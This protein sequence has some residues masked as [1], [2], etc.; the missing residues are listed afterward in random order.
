[1]K[2]KKACLTTLAFL[3]LISLVSCKKKKGSA[4]TTTKENTVVT[5]ESQNNNDQVDKKYQIYLLAQTSGFTGTYEE[6]LESIKGDSV[7]ITVS[8]GKLK[9]KYRNESDYKELLDLSTL[10]G[11]DGSLSI[12]TIGDNGNWF[13]DGEDTLVKARATDG[14]GIVSITK[15]GTVGLVDT[16]T[17]TFT[18]GSETE[19]NIT[20]GQ[21][22]TTTTITSIEKTDT[23]GLVDTY[24]ITFSDNSYY[25]FYVTNGKDGE[26]S[27]VQEGT[28]YRIKDIDGKMYRET[29]KCHGVDRDDIFEEEYEGYM[30]ALGEEYI[31]GWVPRYQDVYTYEAGKLRSI[32]HSKCISFFPVEDWEDNG[33]EVFEYTNNTITNTYYKWQNNDDVP[34]K[35]E[36]T[37]LDSNGD[38]INTIYY[39]WSSSLNDWV[40][41][42]LKYSIVDYS[43]NG[44]TRTIYEYDGITVTKTVSKYKGNSGWVNDS[45][46]ITRAY[47]YYNY[48]D[49]EEENFI[50]DTTNE[51][52]VGTSKDIYKYTDGVL[53]EV[54]TQDYDA[55]KEAWSEE[56][57]HKKQYVDGKLYS[58][59]DMKHCEITNS[60][61]KYGVEIFSRPEYNGS[62][63]IDHIWEDGKETKQ[64][65]EVFG[66]ITI[67]GVKKLEVY[68]KFNKENLSSKFELYE[69]SETSFDDDGN[70][71]NI[72]VKTED[73]PMFVYNMRYGKEYE[74]YDESTNTF[75]TYIFAYSDEKKAIIPYS[76]EIRK[77][78]PG[79]IDGSRH[80]FAI[81]DRYLNYD[82]TTGKWLKIEYNRAT[83]IDE[84]GYVKESRTTKA[85][86]GFVRLYST[87]EVVSRDEK[88]RVTEDIQEVLQE[89][90][91]YI[92]YKTTYTYNELGETALSIT[93]KY[94]NNEWVNAYKSELV[95][96]DGNKSTNYYTWYEDEWILM[97]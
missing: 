52:W 95:D 34:Y 27:S 42:Y 53:E 78:A 63:I 3:S 90:G 15:K 79:L 7:V 35:K 59:C 87:L 55:E 4:K 18:D 68:A 64:R 48:S 50:W 43:D 72:E 9:W 37:E 20:N 61:E 81:F 49:R 94:E 70:I 10:K 14:N 75:T 76:I 80:D 36:V 32:D 97:Q 56:I 71:Y 30:I 54:E 93:Q 21:N 8:D 69:L 29:I 84:D 44:F 96:E 12:L 47:D 51:K 67:E 86:N 45:K 25:N 2:L 88:K 89:N 66:T 46:V 19:F 60:Y 41:D 11:K 57:L 26:G 6:W 91:S 92:K 85:E 73:F 13:I 83:V 62:T 40:E 58:T 17:I 65:M 39:S 82:P 74:Y 16:Y 28:L 23:E 1:M 22:G 5:T 24:T 31:G 33:M 38:A 77:D